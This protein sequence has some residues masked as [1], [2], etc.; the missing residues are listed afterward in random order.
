MFARLAVAR[1]CSLLQLSTNLDSIGLLVV[2]DLNQ[3]VCAQASARSAIRIARNVVK[4]IGLEKAR[5]LG[6]LLPLA[7]VSEDHS[8][9]GSHSLLSKKTGPCFADSVDRDTD[10]LH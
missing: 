2:R 6:G 10:G 4:D 1:L 3:F 5:G 9:R 7:R 8:E